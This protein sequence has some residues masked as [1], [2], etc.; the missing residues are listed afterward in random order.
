MKKQTFAAILLALLPMLAAAQS[1]SAPN[2]RKAILASKY[3]LDSTSYIYCMFTGVNASPWG[4]ALPGGAPV[5]TSGS[6]TTVAATTASTGPF[7]DVAVGDILYIL[8]SGPQTAPV[9]RY[10]TARASADSIT[11]DTA[12]TLTAATFTF[13][14]RSCGTAASSGWVDVSTAWDVKVAWRISQQDTTGGISI[15]V[16]CKD[17]D[18]SGTGT[19]VY[20]P[21]NTGGTRECEDT[22]IFATTTTGC[23]VTIPEGWDSCRLGMKIVTADDGAD[24]TTHTEQ[25]YANIRAR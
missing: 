24:T 18:D 7:T 13:K 12:I 20:P 25:V 5:S 22:G 15:V 8:S 11:V 3:D 14:R 21:N 9:V 10:V 4:G 23:A 2:V 19:R 1:T 6:S 17:N 16:Y